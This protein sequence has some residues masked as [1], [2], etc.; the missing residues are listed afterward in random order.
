MHL[1]ART[2]TTLVP[3]LMQGCTPNQMPNSLRS[4]TR[5]VGVACRPLGVTS[6]QCTQRRHQHRRR[7]LILPQF[8]LLRLQQLQHHHRYRTLL[9][10]RLSLLRLL[11]RQHRYRTLLYPRVQHRLV[12]LSTLL[13]RAGL[14]VFLKARHPPRTPSVAH[15]HLCDEST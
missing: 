2:G 7:T 5:N 12:L 15:P 3:A 13:T 4:T 10:P 11:Q 1:S 9:L 14:A 8:F 6:M